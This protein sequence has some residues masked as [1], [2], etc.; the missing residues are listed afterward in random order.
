[1]LEENLL[2]RMPQEPTVK[3]VRLA[4]KF[5]KEFNQ[6]EKMSKE[7]EAEL[8]SLEYF[9]DLLNV[10]LD[11][12]KVILRLKPKEVKELEEWPMA[13]MTSFAF[14]LFY[15]LINPTGETI[16]ENEKK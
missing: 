4:L 2:E 7:T 6:L 11:F 9:E 15:K 1:M 8:Q 5:G 14:T 16:E 12:L 13:R 10:S 3:Q